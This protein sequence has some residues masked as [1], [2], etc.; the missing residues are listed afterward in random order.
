L[1]VVP[2]SKCFVITQLINFA[3]EENFSGFIFILIYSHTNQINSHA[4]KGI[5]ASIPAQF[6]VIIL[7]ANVHKAQ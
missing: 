5:K 1:L 3:E 4:H 2:V 6:E 7:L